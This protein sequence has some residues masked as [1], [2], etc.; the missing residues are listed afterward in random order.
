MIGII[1][2][3]FEVGKGKKGIG[4]EI[5]AGFLQVIFLNQRIRP[6]PS[7]LIFIPIP[8]VI[9]PP[10]FKSLTI[11]FRRIHVAGDLFKLTQKIMVS[12][13]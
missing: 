1:D 13:F 6:H 3:R 5:E 12:E 8:P 10:C 11:H 4:W 2:I 7:L 9:N